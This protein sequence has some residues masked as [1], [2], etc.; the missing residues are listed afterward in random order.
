M[1]SSTQAVRNRREAPHFLQRPATVGPFGDSSCQ[2]W[3][4]AAPCRPE[5]PVSAGGAE[6]SR[7]ATSCVFQSL[8]VSLTPPFKG[9]RV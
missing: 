2:W 7:P 9:G 5:G 1:N 8:A 6:R 3:T 4:H